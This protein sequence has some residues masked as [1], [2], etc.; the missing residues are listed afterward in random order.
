MSKKYSNTTSD[1]LSW[2]QTLNLIRRLFDDGNYKISLLISIGS[3]FGLRI[4]DLLRL[5]WEDVLKKDSL[6]LVEKKTGKTREI[7]I[8]DQLQRHIT[9]CY[10]KIKPYKEKEFIFTS[11]K[12]SVYSVQRINVIFKDLKRKYNLNV[13]NFSTHSMRKSFGREIFNKSG[14]NAELAL[15]KLSELFNHSNVATTK[16]YLGISKEELM[17]TYDLLEF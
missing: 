9:D 14:T 3:F 7:K 2:D 8:N 5:K 4:S 10:D 1:Y 16:R 6:V 13:K 15:V 11:Q 17:K 12:G